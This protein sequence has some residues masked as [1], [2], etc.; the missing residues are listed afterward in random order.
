MDCSSVRMAAMLLA[1]IKDLVGRANA[2]VLLDVGP[3]CSRG[4][5][6]LQAAIGQVGGKNFV[7][8]GY[9]FELE[10]FG[11]DGNTAVLLDERA[12]GTRTFRDIPAEIRCDAYEVV[13]AALGG[14]C[15]GEL[16]R[17]ACRTGGLDQ[18]G[19][20]RGGAGVSAGATRT[21]SGR[22]PGVSSC[23]GPRLRSARS[24]RRLARGHG[25]RRRSTPPGSCRGAWCRP[26]VGP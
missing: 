7:A 4:T 25:C 2:G 1:D 20:V 11:R 19:E 22:A 6:D 17:I 8:A 24:T 3:R 13:P 23:R 12:G 9:G 16:L 14:G 10:V 26:P 18:S 15:E 5:D 21:V